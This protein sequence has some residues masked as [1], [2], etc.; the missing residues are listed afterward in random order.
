MF[1]TK[2]MS[3]MEDDEFNIDRKLAITSS[4][5]GGQARGMRM[6]FDKISSD[7]PYDVRTLAQDMIDEQQEKADE[8]FDA[9]VKH[10]QAVYEKY[11]D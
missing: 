7:L 11:K 2:R 10:R 4:A 1:Q 6:L 3:K 9:L 8:A 5:E